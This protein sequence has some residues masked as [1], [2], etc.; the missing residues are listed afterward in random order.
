MPELPE[1]ETLRRELSRAVKCKIIKLVQVKWPKLVK[2]LSVKVFTKKL[3][4]Q[5]IISADRR[6]KILLLKLSK[7][8]KK[9]KDCFLAIHLKMTGQLMLRP[10]KGK[11]VI[12][13]HPLPPPPHPPPRPGEGLDSNLPHKHTHIILNFTDGSSLYFNDIRKFGWMKVL[14]EESLKKLSA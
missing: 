9:T 8:D 5:K 2:P 10:K 14:D 4:G 13:G 7:C 1:V 6:A 12:G 11:L 3:I